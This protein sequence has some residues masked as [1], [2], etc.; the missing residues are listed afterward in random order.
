M[1]REGRATIITAMCGL[2]A[3][4]APLGAG[5]AR[6]SRSA[7]VEGPVLW[8]DPG[9]VSRLDLYWGA[10]NEAQAPRE[11]FQFIK[12][13]RSGT[14]PKLHL[15]DANGVKWSVKFDRRSGRGREI[16]AEIAAS[17]IAWALG[18]F[19]ES[20]YLVRDGTI[21]GVDRLTRGR[22]VLDE[23]GRFALA[24]FEPRPDDVKR[25][26]I[27]WTV[28]D[29]PFA[30]SQE[31]SGL[32]V[33][34]ALLNNWDFR[35]GNTVVLR[36]PTDTGT[37]TRYLVS[38]WGTTFGRMSPRRSRWDLEDYRDQTPFFTVVGDEVELNLHADDDP[39]RSRVPRAHARWFTALA[40]QLTVEQLR[41]AFE[42][43]GATEEE[44]FG[45]AETV[46]RRIDT[47]HEALRP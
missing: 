32:V 43:G 46:K 6:V 25:L 27:R 20:S 14:K 13:D 29:N 19:V 26:D 28:A 42:A 2:A 34:A 36:V 33:L 15:R 18:Y 4:P 40:S 31:L 39:G 45:L 22:R 47:L 8:R 38:D 9:P 23:R 44:Q 11:P 7:V 35:A 21:E 1:M 17:R 41:R 10:A 16:P 24:R 37:E 3:A 5:P 30:G 12:E